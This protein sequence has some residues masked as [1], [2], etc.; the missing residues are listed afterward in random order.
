MNKI[1]EMKFGSHLYG[2]QTPESDVDIKGIYIPTAREIVLGTYRRT[3]N[4]SRKKAQNERNTKDDVDTEFFSLDRFLELLAE[5]QTVA[6]DM[7]FGI[8]DSD[9][10]TPRGVE[11]IADIRA[12]LDKLLTK[13]INAFIGYA[14]QQAARYGVKGSRMDALKRSLEVLDSLPQHD[15]LSEHDI[16][17]AALLES[18]KNL[19]SLENT[20]LIDIATIRTPNGKDEPHLQIC[21]RKFPMHAKIGYTKQIV[22]RILD[23]YGSR[24]QKAHLAGGKDFKALSHA[25][26]VNSEAVE[27]LT[28]GKI[29]FPRPDADVLLKIKTMQMRYEDVAE[30]IETGVARLHD[31]HLKSRLPERHDQSYIDNLVYRHY[32][33]VV[34]TGC[35]DGPKLT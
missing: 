10:L 12:N 2:T 22:K 25:V 19:V 23:E 32:A 18:S 9:V 27:L 33:D 11:I 26:R 35:F 21:G 17:W 15:T 8:R 20:A 6:L 24:A 7:L 30:L 34:V 14:R 5:G 4:S 16:I 13:N 3:V 1:V 29:T 28:T 31:I